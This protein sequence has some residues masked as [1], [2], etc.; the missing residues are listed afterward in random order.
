MEIKEGSEPPSR[1]D[2][3][4]GLIN[5]L[6]KFLKQFSQQTASKLS[7]SQRDAFIEKSIEEF[8]SHL[9]TEDDILEE[10]TKDMIHGVVDLP[11][12]TV[13]E[14]MVP[15]VDMVGIQEGASLKD[16]IELVKKYG[17]SRFPFF[18][19][20]LDDIKGILYIK[21]IFVDGFNS[22][23]IAVNTETRPSYF[24]PE[25][26]KVSDLLKEMRKQKVHLAIAVDE[27]GGTA[28]LITL[29]DIL[30]EIVGE[31]EDEY[32]QDDPAIL[33]LDDTHFSVKGSLP[34]AEL[35]EE[36]DLDLPE[37]QFETVGG[38]I[39]DIVGSL[40]RQGTTVDYKCLKFTATKVEGQRITRVTVELKPENLKNNNFPDQSID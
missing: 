33:K 3:R 5:S 7:P 6:K 27:Y 38:V 1:G 24:V 16:I 40:P 11:Q 32:D 26:K 9:S 23:D 17:H 20:S 35:N 29:E 18:G 25:N 19:E 37:D 28:G 12:T 22:G 30:E 4:S 34:I 39:Y 36:L 8:S 21:D 15:R 13:K 2:Q 14:I 10:A 31:I